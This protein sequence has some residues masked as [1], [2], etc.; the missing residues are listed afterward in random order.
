MSFL[1]FTLDTRMACATLTRSEHSEFVHVMILRGEFYTFPC[2]PLDFNLL[3]V[4]MAHTTGVQWGAFHT[5]V[6]HQGRSAALCPVPPHAPQGPWEP[7]S[8]Q[9]CAFSFDT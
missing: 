4:P 3:Q 2:F 9:C 6:T 1:I 5:S 8:G 7:L